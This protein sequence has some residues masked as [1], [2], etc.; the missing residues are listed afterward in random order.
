MHLAFDRGSRLLGRAND[1]SESSSLLPLWIILGVGAVLAVAWFALSS[2]LGDHAREALGDKLRSLFSRGGRSAAN[3]GASGSRT[4][5]GRM[6]DDEAEAFDISAAE[7]D[8]YDDLD[9]RDAYPP[10]ASHP[11]K[12]DDDYGKL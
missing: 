11:S 9:P 7:N 4:A 8:L 12:Y 10:T 1:G 2:C 5:Y 3:G 6:R